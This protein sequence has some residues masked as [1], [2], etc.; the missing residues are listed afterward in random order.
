MYNIHLL[1]FG[2]YYQLYLANFGYCK[3]GLDVGDSFRG[4]GAECSHEKVNR[5]C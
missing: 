4:L 1:I 3:I 2:S 5:H